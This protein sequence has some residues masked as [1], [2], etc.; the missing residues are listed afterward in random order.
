M[1]ATIELDRIRTHL[2]SPGQP[3]ELAERMV[4]GVPLQVYK[5]LPPNLSHLIVQAAAHAERVFVVR[6]EERFTYAA[7]LGR[8]AGLARRLRE[9]YGAG[10]GV[11]V[12]IAA[13]EREVAA[14]V[15]QGK[16]NRNIAGDLVVSERTV[17]THVTN[18]LLKLGFTSRSQ[19]AAWAAHVGLIRQ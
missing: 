7:F 19:I 9:D 11:R 10:V 18:I 6:G 3:F 14:L 8:A 17:E 15:A 4:N 2:S 13:R 12:A 1:S 16:S 5:H